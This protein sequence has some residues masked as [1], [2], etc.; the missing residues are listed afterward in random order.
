MKTS[1]FIYCPICNQEIHPNKMKKELMDKLDER[2][3][4]P[5]TGGYLERY[6]YKTYTLK[7]VLFRCPNDNTVLNEFYLGEVET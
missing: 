7:Y 2:C 5:L 6:E 1:E 3:I 4:N